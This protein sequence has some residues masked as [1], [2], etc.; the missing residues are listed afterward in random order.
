[1]TRT[2][3][4]GNLIRGLFSGAPTQQK[5]AIRDK[6]QRL[7]LLELESRVVPASASFLN[8]TLT[9]SLASGDYFDYMNEYRDAANPTAVNDTAGYFKMSRWN[10]TSNKFEPVAWAGLT[11]SSG[12]WVKTQ[13]GVGLKND[14]IQLANGKSIDGINIVV[15]GTSSYEGA[16][17]RANPAKKDGVFTGNVE[18]EAS[19]DDTVVQDYSFV[20]KGDVRFLG[21]TV[22]A[23]EDILTSKNLTISSATGFFYVEGARTIQAGGAGYNLAIN[24]TIEGATA[25]G[26]ILNRALISNAGGPVFLGGGS[27]TYVSSNPPLVLD[28]LD[29]TGSEIS[30]K[31]AF[32]YASDFMR[33]HGPVTLEGNT[34]LV[35]DNELLL[36][37]GITSGA[38]ARTLAIEVNGGGV[39]TVNAL[40]SG[41][42][43]Q[44]SSLDLRPIPGSDGAKVIWAGSVKT[45]SA[46]GAAIKVS[47]PLYLNG[48]VKLETSGSSTT[49]LVASGSIQSNDPGKPANLD[50]KT[51]QMLI[52]GKLGNENPLGS[53][54][55]NGSLKTLAATSIS[56]VGNILQTGNTNDYS[57]V[58][59]LT[60]TSLE[61]SI[62]LPNWI[63]KGGNTSDP[64]PALDL[65]APKGKLEL[66]T[67]TTKTALSL[68]DIKL[69]ARDGISLSP[70]TITATGPGGIS[71]N[72][73]L[74]MTAD[75]ILTV[76]D[77]T[78]PL[79]VG[80]LE[81]GSP[82]AHS[83]TLNAAGGPVTILSGI[84]QTNALK[85]FTVD[86]G[87]SLTVNGAVK[88]DSFIFLK[89]DGLAIDAPMTSPTISV[90][91]LT[92]GKT[93][94]L[95][96][97]TG[98]DLALSSAE[99][100]NLVGGVINLGKNDTGLITA[101]GKGAFSSAT[102][103]VQI[104]APEGIATLNNGGISVE[105]LAINASKAV[106]LSGANSVK[107]LG[108]QFA[109]DLLFSNLGG[110]NLGSDTVPF[111][112]VGNGT[113]SASG[114][115]TQGATVSVGGTLEMTATLG[116]GQEQNITL[117]NPANSIPSVRLG[118]A[119]AVQLVSKG[120]LK[121]SQ[122]TVLEGSTPVP[123]LIGS[124]EA[125]SGSAN[126]IL[127]GSNLDI[128]GPINLT[129]GTS[130][131]LSADTQIRS[132]AQSGDGI[133]IKGTV[134]DATG[135]S[136]VLDAGGGALVVDGIS[137]SG[138]LT[139]P[140]LGGNSSIGTLKAGSVTVQGG[141]GTLD[142]NAPDTATL[143]IGGGALNVM[144]DSL[145]KVGALNAN[146]TGLTTLGAIG[147][148][149]TMPAGAVVNRL[150]T[151]NGVTTV[152]F[153][154]G[155]GL[156][157]AFTV[158]KGMTL[159]AGDSAGDT[160]NLPGG[161][162]VASGG[163]LIGSGTLKGNVI[164]QSGGLYAPTD[165]TI[166]GNL[167]LDG[168]STLQ[169]PGSTTS[170]SNGPL[171]VN[172]VA[173]IADAM[174]EV[175]NAGGQKP[176]KDQVINAVDTGSTGTLA[177]TF[178]GLENG[179]K[180]ATATGLYLVTYANGDA[181][182]TAADEPIKLGIYGVAVMG[183]PSQFSRLD[184]FENGTDRF[185]RSVDAFP[186]F[187]GEFYVDSGDVTGDGIEDI[188]VGSGNGSLN[189]HVVLFDGERLLNPTSTDTSYGA[190]GTVL[191]S[192]YAF[193]NY[194]SGVAVRLAEV[195]GDGIDDI[196]LSPGTGAGTVTQSHLR[197]WD[198]ALS[199]VQFRRGDPFLSYNYAQ[200]ELASFYAFGGDGAPGGGMAI[201]VIR[202]P[203][204]PGG[205]QIVA[206]QLFGGGV[207]VFENKNITTPKV[208]NTVRDFT[209][210]LPSGNTVVGVNGTGGE[211]YYI[212][213]GT[214]AGNRDT[215]YL[216]DQ[217]GT[218]LR[219]VTDVFGGTQGGLRV[220]IQNTDKDGQDELLVIRDTIAD[221]AS[222]EIDLTGSTL[223]L[224]PK[225][226]AN[227][228]GAGGWV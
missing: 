39:A 61:G 51:L 209:N 104:I 42:T 95:G 128:S 12:T 117:N 15:K 13:V 89:V 3:I 180:L 82:G 65:S 166:T 167:N 33:F 184:I 76:T 120:D 48:D 223:N 148:I 181:L 34:V 162:T 116:L 141:S 6:A 157:S 199:T 66:Y 172:G 112:V 159:A 185:I 205:D 80:G 52:T 106:N 149:L 154:N 193:I 88:A 122:L 29:V 208:L 70:P 165:H 56:A 32:H 102:G 201:N 194:S 101:G 64:A 86:K 137:L 37:Q 7:K 121:L 100:A 207:R 188:I 50:I 133:F 183:N 164:V 219:T 228:G 1:M 62:T 24:S 198:G 30:L 55:L 114:P 134:V 45:T 67:G 71:I 161:L 196:V 63:V 2:S 23:Y 8:N 115:I 126:R 132:T 69:N 118:Y 31:G 72:G 226:R 84:G 97:N 75:T 40:P 57:M 175:V 217:N 136:L 203:G 179:A 124:L 210:F 85:N 177:G 4:L 145:A 173:T 138:G 221:V 14:S 22:S 17:F 225:G 139:I 96:A 16:Y 74:T 92:A 41:A 144:I 227:R 83:L 38:T 142:L 151:A 87:S 195:T 93:M 123:A 26:T 214:N 110:L 192:L 131:P 21:T 187:R 130:I 222:Y 5:K 20:S 125:I 213:A 119:D 68:V 60:A 11:D 18:T 43:A 170:V 178:S 202:N 160:L 168:G 105:T 81:S 163:N 9:I 215:L 216:R 146:N 99:I 77:A 73:P 108:G 10:S 211:R 224:V 176:S 169:I 143:T 182:L 47:V 189:G 155:G 53:F 19:V 147:S 78:A 49:N 44:F 58:G 91:N 150:A 98:A 129:S 153:P 206:S 171:T 174:L 156:L 152:S 107:N 111:A 158:A 200:W 103:R 94:V 220:S 190:G 140:S 35:T 186:G 109:N 27:G 191:A 218:V 59:R 113:L 36:E 135:K 127:F 79:S 212:S 46:S 28:A 90:Q 54:T 197:V 204:V 25:G